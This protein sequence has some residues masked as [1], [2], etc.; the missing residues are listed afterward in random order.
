M[1]R[2]RLDAQGIRLSTTRQDEN[3]IVAEIGRSIII[4]IKL[5]ADFEKVR[6]SPSSPRK[7]G[8]SGNPRTFVIEMDS[9]FRGND[10]L[11]TAGR[12]R[13]WLI[14]IGNAGR[15]REFTSIS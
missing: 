10:D 8:E 7:W 4:P 12:W 6:H 15:M 5:G 14:L 11:K 9:R 13:V 2:K 1:G 3:P